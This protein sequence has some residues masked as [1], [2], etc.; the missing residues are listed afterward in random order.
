M[1]GGGKSE[2][3]FNAYCGVTVCVF[4]FA[5]LT[6]VSEADALEF[7]VTGT[8]TY[9][10]SRDNLVK[11][12]KTK[13][14]R[15]SVKDCEWNAKT[16]DPQNPIR[17]DEAGFQ[18]DSIFVLR[19]FPPK[20]NTA[21]AVY[22]ATIYP[23]LM[24]SEDESLINYL[25]LA[26]GSACY[27]SGKPPGMLEPVWELD[28]P[29]LNVSGFKMQAFWEIGEGIPKIPSS[30]A[31]INDGFYRVRK[32]GKP[33]S[34][35]AKPPFDKGYTNAIFLSEGQVN[36]K[37]VRLPS[38]SVFKRFYLANSTPVKINEEARLLTRTEITASVLK[39]NDVV[40]I[41]SFLPYFDGVIKTQDRRARALESP[42]PNIY[43]PITNGNW[44]FSIK[45]KEETVQ[46]FAAR[47]A[48][49]Q[50]KEPGK[51]DGGLRAA[52]LVFFFVSAVVIPVIIFKINSKK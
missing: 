3:H 35:K 13:L 18:N 50:L 2:I 12:E 16:W 23:G 1:K 47:A 48:Q 32:D 10:A 43:Y 31:Y 24:P 14:F 37:D 17:Y 52:V 6:C 34:F 40:S 29:V 26:Y 41:K 25:W 36:C 22:V 33:F 15:F 7:E 9:K 11:Y 38:V 30:I 39:L 46:K 8:V 51:I 4:I 49:A 27:F 42:G 19:C 5:L 45:E 20:T 21:T 44:P 28:D